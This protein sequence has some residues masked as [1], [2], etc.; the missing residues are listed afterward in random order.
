MHETCTTFKV[1]S[2]LLLERTFPRSVRYSLA[3]AHDAIGCIRTET[4]TAGVDPAER[5]LGRLNA[6]LEYAEP[7]EILDLGIPAYVQ[8]IQEQ[9]AEAGLAVQKRYFLY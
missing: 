7:S 5:I 6:Q 3:K 9:V 4:G 2:F 8:K 1:A